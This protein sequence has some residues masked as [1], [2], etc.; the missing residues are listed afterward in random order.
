[1]MDACAYHQDWGSPTCKTDKRGNLVSDW[2]DTNNLVLLNNGEPTRISPA[3]SLS[4]ID[5]T[6]CSPEIS[7]LFNWFPHYDPCE[8]DHFPI[9]LDM[10]SAKLQIT[11]NPRWKTKK[12]DWAKYQEA[13]CIPE[14]FLSPTQACGSV[15][16]AILQ[17]AELTIPKIDKTPHLPSAYWWNHSCTIAKKAKKRALN[18]YRRN[19]GNLEMWN[20]YQS[21]SNVFRNTVKEAR[22]ESWKELLHNINTNTTSRDVWTH[23]KK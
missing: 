13:L 22:E 16:K 9:I 8:S 10:P 2:I 23:I 15:T 1:M 12:A 7:L 17:A 3:G 14:E 18:R 20:I 5:L 19:K 11:N 6:V 4:H 21:A